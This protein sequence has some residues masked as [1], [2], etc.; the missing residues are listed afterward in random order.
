MVRFRCG[1]DILAKASFD[2]SCG[3]VDEH[4]TPSTNTPDGRAFE[5]SVFSGL[6]GFSLRANVFVD[7]TKP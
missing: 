2:Q 1:E 7:M 4:V 5:L 6:L 3:Q